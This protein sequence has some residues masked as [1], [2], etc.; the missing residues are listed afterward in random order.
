MTAIVF[1][2][3]AFYGYTTKRDLTKLGSIVFIGLIGVLIGSLVNMLIFKS[4][5]ADMGIAILGVIVFVGYIAYDVNKV[6]YLVDA[7]GEDKAAV[8]GAFQL[9]LDFINL[10]I[11]LLQLFGKKND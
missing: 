8:Y 4:A 6:K 3:L 11:R 2:L 10:F 7:V 9:Y 5:A 1:A